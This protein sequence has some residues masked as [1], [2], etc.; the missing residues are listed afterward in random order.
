MTRY[1]FQQWDAQRA[2]RN[3]ALDA[4]LESLGT[5]L[6]PPSLHQ[7][8]SGS[9]LFGSQ[10]SLSD[11]TILQTDDHQGPL[12]QDPKAKWKSLRD[13]LDEKGIED[14]LDRIEE[15]RSNLDVCTELHFWDSLSF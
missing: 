1:N 7:M 10:H 13:F 15:E 6:V 12:S 8:S 11:P 14:T 4:I 3:Q 2:E 5:Q 9:S